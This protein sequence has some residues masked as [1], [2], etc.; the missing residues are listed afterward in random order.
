MN[1]SAKHGN[2]IKFTMSRE[3]T[4]ERTEEHLENANKPETLLENG[5]CGHRPSRREMLGAEASQARSGS[6]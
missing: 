5:K 3:N 2:C 6:P 1:N 4:S